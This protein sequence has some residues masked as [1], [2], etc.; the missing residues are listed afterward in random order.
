MTVIF[1]QPYAHHQA[2]IKVR[3]VLNREHHATIALALQNVS[4]CRN[5]LKILMKV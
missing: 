2:K 4:N 3:G 5:K 1:L